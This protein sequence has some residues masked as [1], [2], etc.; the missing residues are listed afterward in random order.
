L[1]QG[2]TTGVAFEAGIVYPV[3]SVV[4]VARVVFCVMCC[5]SL[6]VCFHIVLNTDPFTIHLTLKHQVNCKAV[7]GKIRFIAKTIFAKNV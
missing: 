2:N 1:N 6:F 3:L 4:H 7:N 5:A